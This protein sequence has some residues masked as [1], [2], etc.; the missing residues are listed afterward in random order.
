MTLWPPEISKAKEQSRAGSSEHQS[1]DK[2]D[3]DDEDE[4]DDSH[5][6]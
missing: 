5:D 6:G 3:H 1:T 4:D 2:D